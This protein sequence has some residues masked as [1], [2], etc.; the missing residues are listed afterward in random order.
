MDLQKHNS[1]SPEQSSDTKLTKLS[2]DA[3][4]RLR[5][6]GMV[7]TGGGF[8]RASESRVMPARAQIER[9]PRLGDALS[10]G[11]LED[12]CNRWLQYANNMLEA[13]D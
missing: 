2:A 6:S 8:K 9:P 13:R 10:A 3:R 4:Q 1:W 11:S 7:R 5:T 12:G